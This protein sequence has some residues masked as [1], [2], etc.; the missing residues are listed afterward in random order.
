MR[1]TLYSHTLS[2]RALPI[3][4]IGINGVRYG[5]VIDTGLFGNDFRTVLVVPY[6]GAIT[7]GTFAFG[8]QESDDG[9]SWSAVADSQ[10]QG[11]LPSIVAADDFRHTNL[12]FGVIPTKQY[13]RVSVT[14]SGV[15]SG[16]SI[17]AT[18]VLAGASSSPALRTGS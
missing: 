7:D 2:V 11:G 1:W 10:I 9:N 14:A 17:G 6:T 3:T 18:A 5:S 12:D 8:V 13:L 16:G 4:S 15:S